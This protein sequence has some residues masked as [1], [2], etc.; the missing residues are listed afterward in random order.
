MTTPPT[1]LHSN[2]VS[3][4]CRLLTEYL[5]KS[6]DQ[7]TLYV[8][9]AGLVK[10]PNTWLEPDLFYVADAANARRDPKYPNYLTTAELVI[11]VISEESAIY[12]RN[13]KADTYAVLG[14]KELWLIDEAS[15]IIEIRILE[16]DRY[17]P[18]VVLESDDQL[19]SV[20][21]SGFEIRVGSVFGA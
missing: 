9:R 13:T 6:N 18:S 14:V 21:L 11:E 15:G 16:G 8:P 17:A 12:D 1:L 5:I 10:E 7:G 4:L 3:R 20:A 2:T 19:R